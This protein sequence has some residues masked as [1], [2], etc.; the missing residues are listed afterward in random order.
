MEQEIIK[1]LDKLCTE[2][3]FCLPADK[4]SE[5][6]KLKDPEAPEFARLVLEA[7][8]MNPETELAWFRKIRNRFTEQF[9]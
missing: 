2:W 9:G 3:G 7:E 8:G 6:S 5:L 1:F 4:I